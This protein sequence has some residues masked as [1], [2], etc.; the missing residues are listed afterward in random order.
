[1]SG[2]T[3]SP[4]PDCHGCAD[5][6][7]HPHAF[8]C[9]RSPQGATPE[10]PATGIGLAVGAMADRAILS[11]QPPLAPDDGDISNTPYARAWQTLADDAVLASSRITA[12]RAARLI[13]TALEAERARVA[14]PRDTTTTTTTEQEQ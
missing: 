11:G 12:T 2:N 9:D 8:D 4:A 14:E 10:P 13:Q 5:P 3:S 1:M 7:N 6:A